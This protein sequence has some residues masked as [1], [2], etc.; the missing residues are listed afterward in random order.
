MH[1]LRQILAWFFGLMLLA[2]FGGP[3]AQTS[4]SHAQLDQL[5]APVALYPDALLSQVLM[6]ATYP[7]DV[8]SANAM[9]EGQCEPVRRCCHQRRQPPAVGPERAIAGGI[10]VGDG[11]DGARAPVGAV[12]R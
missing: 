11:H 4:L 3:M 9:V 2:P 12:P 1:R 6:A 8:A 7:A 5:T 10:S